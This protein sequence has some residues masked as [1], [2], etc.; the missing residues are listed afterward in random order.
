MNFGP[1]TAKKWDRSFRAPSV[2]S[3][4]CF[5]ARHCTRRSANGTQPNFAERKEVGLN[6]LDASRIR[7]RHIANVN[8]KIKIRSLVSRGHKTLYVSNGIPPGG[9]HWQYIVNWH[10]HI[11]G[12]NLDFSGVSKIVTYPTLTKLSTDRTS[13]I[14][15]VVL[16]V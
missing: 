8:A 10:Y 3:V 5:V 13:Y 7:W 16:N 14:F 15:I 6:G 2:N 12:R 1:Q 9:L 4:F 11:L